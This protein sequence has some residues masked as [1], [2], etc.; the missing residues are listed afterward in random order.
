MDV[1]ASD[2][3]A[4]LN[5]LWKIPIPMNKFMG[6]ATLTDTVIM[7]RIFAGAKTVY[8]EISLNRTQITLEDAIVNFQK[9]AGLR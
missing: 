5:Y 9:V 6:D 7:L 4:S 1:F 8:P 3:I 2:D